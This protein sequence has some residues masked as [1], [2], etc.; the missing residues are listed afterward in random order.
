MQWLL[1]YITKQLHA[2][3]EGLSKIK[4][5]AVVVFFLVYFLLFL[6]FS[7]K[8]KKCPFDASYTN[9]KIKGIIE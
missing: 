9:K 8:Q 2:E 6:S 4:T 7:V 1:K 5:S 3:Q